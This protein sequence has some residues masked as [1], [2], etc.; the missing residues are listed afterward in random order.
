MINHEAAFG[1]SEATIRLS[2]SFSLGPITWSIEPGDRWLV[3]GENG[4]GKSALLSALSGMGDCVSGDRAVPT[5]CAVVSSGFQNALIEEEIALE[6]GDLSGQVVDGTKAASILHQIAQDDARLEQLVDG[7]SLGGVLDKAFRSLS[8]GETRKLLLAR[9]LASTA[10]TLILDEPFQ[11][12]DAESLAWMMDQFDSLL[13]GRTLILATNKPESLPCGVNQLMIMARGQVE[14][15][16]AIDN[17]D[18]VEWLAHIKHLAGQPGAIP[19]WAERDR[20]SLSPLV[21]L[22]DVTIAYGGQAVFE[23]LNW[24]IRP[25]EHWQVTGPNGAG[26]TSLLQLITG[27]H[28]QCYV[29]DVR[30]FGFKRGSGESIWDVKRYIGVVSS[31]IQVAH[32][33]STSVERTL[34]SG[35]YDSIGLYQKATESE[36]AHA[37][38]W[39]ERL[40]LTHLK[41]APFSKLSFGAQ[42]LV[43][44]AR[45]M[46]KSPPLLLL[47]EPCLGLDS[48]NRVLVLAFIEQLIEQEETAIVYVSHDETDQIA[49]I[50]RVLDMSQFLP[51][52]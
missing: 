20:V 40:G 38:I 1:L 36:R 47:D 43:L 4:A 33:M 49:S 10:D 51:G 19:I 11:G 34:L 2:Y 6:Q 23:N 42:R 44:I 32:R 9:A 18:G 22:K 16:S 25:N 14:E 41:Q 26:K 24:A 8:T 17:E 35:F 13:G 28:P 45:S 37:S 12:L 5:Q 21:E 50:D 31:S 46:I 52:R 39:L 48:K 30:V 15:T 27:D 29:N 7:L 3:L